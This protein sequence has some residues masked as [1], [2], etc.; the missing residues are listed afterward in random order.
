MDCKSYQLII[1]RVCADG[2]MLSFLSK[3]IS[4]GYKSVAK[5][6]ASSKEPCFWCCVFE[7]LFLQQFFFEFIL[8][9]FCA[10]V[11]ANA[12]RVFFS[13]A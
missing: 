9:K 6:H 11:F 10:K 4:L 1:V 5:I 8:V 7:F 3:S 12:L 13:I 2:E